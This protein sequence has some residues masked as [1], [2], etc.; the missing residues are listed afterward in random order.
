MRGL[1]TARPLPS[2]PLP[3]S[4]VAEKREW[5]LSVRLAPRPEVADDRRD[6]AVTVGIAC[7]VCT[8][9]TVQRKVELVEKRITKLTETKKR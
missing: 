4:V 2:A 6:C 5:L 8:A 7:D 3:L 9:E 1:R